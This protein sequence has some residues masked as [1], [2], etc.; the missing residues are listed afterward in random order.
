MK[1]IKIV[2]LTMLIAVFGSQALMASSSN[3]NLAYAFGD[4]VDISQVELLTPQ[5]ME[6]TQGKYWNRSFSV[7]SRGFVIGYHSPHH[8]FKR[9]YLQ[10]RRTHLQLTTYRVG[11]KRSQQHYRVPLWR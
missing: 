10:G 4:S 2:L 6:D 5:E 9:G 8:N 3:D 1:H 11:V 7:G